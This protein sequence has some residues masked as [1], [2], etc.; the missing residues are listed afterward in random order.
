MDS[1]ID[2]TGLRRRFW[3]KK[4]L[5]DLNRQEWEALCDGC[6]KCCVLKL[7]DEDTGAVH[8]TDVACRLFDADTCSCGNY[9]LRKQLV[10]GCVVLTPENIERN[11][12][13]MPKTC[14]Y[15]LLQESKPLP[16]WHPLLT[17]DLRSTDAAGMSVRGRVCA[18][19]EV[20]EQDLED[21]VLEGF[22]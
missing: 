15:R 2:R 10:A 16:D 13:W 12:H 6:G 20:D 21:H 9:P 11:A 3:K 7:E 22:L 19:Y 14:T 1:V 5:V 4:P 8:Y 17:G 18:E